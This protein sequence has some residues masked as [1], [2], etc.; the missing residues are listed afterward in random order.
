MSKNKQLQSIAVVLKKSLRE[1]FA[2]TQDEL[3]N[4]RYEKFKRM[5]EI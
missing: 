4:H 1:L 3:V 2:M 5:G